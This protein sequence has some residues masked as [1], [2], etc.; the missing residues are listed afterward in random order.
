MTA[1]DFRNPDYIPI[2]AE[3]LR[4]LQWLRENPD[5]VPAVLAYYRT[6][7]WALIDDWGMTSDT[8]NADIGLPVK[9]PFVLMPRQREW[10]EWAY[11]LWQNRKPGVTEKS[12]DCGVS[13]LSVA[14]GCTIC[15]THQ[16]VNIGYGSRKEEYVDKAGAP[17]ALFFK[18]RQ[19]L[20]LLPPELTHGWAERRNAKH[21]LISFP[22]GSTM[23]G[24]AGDSI[25]RGDR[26]AIYFVDESAFLERPQLAEGGLAATTNC[27]IDISSANGTDNPFYAKIQSYPPEQKFRFHW[28]DDPRKDQAWY[29]QQ[30]RELDPVTVAQEIDINYSAAKTGIVIP[31]EWVQAAIDLDQALGVEVS[32]AKR[33]ALDVA[34]EGVDLNA[35]AWSRGVLLEG[36]EEWSG[37]GSDIFYTVSH[38]FDLCDQHAIGEFRFDADGLGAGVR[39]DARV[40]NATRKANGVW[41]VEVEPFRGSGEIYKP[42]APIPTADPTPGGRNRLDR[43][44]GDYFHNAKAQGWWELRIRFQRAYRTRVALA[45]GQ[46]APYALDDMIVLRSTM[47]NLG[48][49][50]TE[51]SQPTYDKTAAGKILIDKAPDKARSPNLGDSVMILFAPRRRSFLSA[52]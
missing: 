28:R 43:K 8:R 47:P 11:G 18:A 9:V 1:F 25:G 20:N 42:D 3:R 40:L 4:R 10:L 5:Q 29:E 30:C 41:E 16:N 6:H 12:R 26:A 37:K 22:T 15:L 46:A 27:R 51:L 32:G 19:F 7:P 44:N 45:A 21:M 14:L 35:L 23:T 24:E 39:G 50:T 31:P 36:V 17:K 52:I 2:Y 38:A 33:G 13:W 34:D 49:L 48:K